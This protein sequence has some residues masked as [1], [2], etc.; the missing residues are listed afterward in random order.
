MKKL[1]SKREGLSIVELS[2]VNLKA[3][4]ILT[5]TNNDIYIATPDGDLI[6]ISTGVKYVYDLVEVV[7]QGD[8]AYLFESSREAK[9]WIADNILT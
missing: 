1:V 5:K 6:S 8:E 3:D 2:E 7:E 4:V 9:E